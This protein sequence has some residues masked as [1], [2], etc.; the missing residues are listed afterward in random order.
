MENQSAHAGAAIQ[1]G[2]SPVIGGGLVPGQV[3]CFGK[4]NFIAADLVW[5]PASAALPKARRSLLGVCTF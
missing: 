2:S 1:A 5:D 3:L 4:L